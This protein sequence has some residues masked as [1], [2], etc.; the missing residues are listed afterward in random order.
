MSIKVTSLEA[1]LYFLSVQ[2]E[3]SSN[4]YFEN[5][6]VEYLSSYQINLISLN[7]RELDFLNTYFT[8]KVPKKILLKEMG[9]TEDKY[10]SDFR[11]ILKKIERK[12]Y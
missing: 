12:L 2:K 9:I 7:D 1:E 5:A 10:Y 11:K 6:L 4:N 3:F 8:S